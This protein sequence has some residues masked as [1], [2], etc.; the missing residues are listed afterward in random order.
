MLINRDGLVWIGHRIVQKGDAE[1]QGVGMWWQ[2]PQGGIDEGEDLEAAAMRELAEETGVTSAE[3]IEASPR[4]C[5][6]CADS[7]RT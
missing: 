6:V 7:I 4:W 3:I 2:M 5:S 1:A